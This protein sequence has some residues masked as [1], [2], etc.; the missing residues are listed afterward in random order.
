MKFL[1]V[2]CDE[3]MKLKETQGPDEGSMTVV[4]QCPMC[5]KEIAMLTNPMETQV[6]GSLGVSIGTKT[7]LSQPM[8]G[9]KNSLAEKKGD[10]FQTKNS[11]SKCPFTDVVTDAFSKHGS[12][13]VIWT[14]EAEE[15]L[16]RIPSFIRPMAKKGIEQY[17]NEN[18]YNQ[19]DDKVMD[20]VK[21]MYGM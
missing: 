16:K 1:C 9:L 21:D 20:A 5:E 6:V 11:D 7:T 3:P 13:D 14:K 15:R 12:K 17:A 2:E 19:V 8:Q 18:G 10:L 4:Y